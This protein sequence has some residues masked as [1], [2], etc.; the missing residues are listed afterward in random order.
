M[1]VRLVTSRNYTLTVSTDTTIRSLNKLMTHLSL[2]PFEL[3]DTVFPEDVNFTHQHTY[4]MEYGTQQHSHPQEPL[5]SATT[6]SW[7]GRVNNSIYPVADDDEQANE[8]G[9]VCVK[10]QSVTNAV[11]L[12][13]V[14]CTL[15]DGFSGS[16]VNVGCVSRD[17]TVYVRHRDQVTRLPELT[18]TALHAYYAYSQVLVVSD[19]GALYRYHTKTQQFTCHSEYGTV[20][21]LGIIE[22][23]VASMIP[24]GC[25]VVIFRNSGVD[26]TRIFKTWQ[27]VFSEVLS[28][29]VRSMSALDR[30]RYP[31]AHQRIK[32]SSG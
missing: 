23:D 31:S 25:V 14:T 3:Q 19:R 22:T 12:T 17:N 10:D 4:S 15:G 1:P 16:R 32:G 30:V 21:E 8:L 11:S 29:Q 6:E 26:E 27:C 20:K 7:V 24:K 18:F 13:F 5:S 2:Q 28:T 9:C